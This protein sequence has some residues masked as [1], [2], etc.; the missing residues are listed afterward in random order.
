ML[1]GSHQTIEHLLIVAAEA[2]SGKL[3]SAS[4]AMWRER[5]E[6]VSDASRVMGEHAKLEM[7]KRGKPGITYSL[8]DLLDELK[9]EEEAYAQIS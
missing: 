4:G 5:L 7:H 3:A 1:P 8:H 6:D 9:G 2:Q